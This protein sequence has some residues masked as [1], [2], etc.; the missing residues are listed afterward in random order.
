MDFA[1]LVMGPLVGG[2]FFLVMFG[3]IARFLFFFCALV[4]S[5]KAKKVHWRYLPITLGKS[6]LPF[7]KA[8]KKITVVA[9]VR[10]IFHICVIAVPLLASGH[11]VWLQLSSLG[12]YWTPLPDALIDRL[13]LLVIGLAVFFF[14]RRF[15]I[16][17]IR[18]NS[19]KSDYILIFVTALPFLTG[20]IAYHQWFDYESVLILHILS[21]A[22][23]LVVTLFLFCRTYLDV[24]K[25]IG[26]A[27]C[28][29]NCPTGTIEYQDEEKWRIF[30]YS[31]Y[32]CVSCAACVIT[33]PEEA[34]ELR[35]EVSFRRY[36]QIAG[37]YVIRSVE[38]REC[39]RC[40]ARYAPELQIDR[41]RGIPQL[42]KIC[43]IMS[44]EHLRLC[45]QCR[46]AR[47]ADVLYRLG[48]YP[49]KAKNRLTIH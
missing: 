17:D 48:P 1:S 30:S 22:V 38:L 16:P 42:Q 13:T 26:C 6:L 8:I 19:L 41:I 23:M 18:E 20:F 12:W 14:T 32:Q 40:G 35:H 46:K 31:H 3:V 5:G 21:G 45:P 10:Y 49:K 44:E 34:A 37:K 28:E 2:V 24:K 9:T 4:R 11:L 27:A 36:F 29:I 25:C 7:H 43:A 47:Q 15:I 33:C 39:K